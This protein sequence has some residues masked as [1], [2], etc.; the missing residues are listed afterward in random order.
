M[1]WPCTVCR[2]DARSRKQTVP[3]DLLGIIDGRGDAAERNSTPLPVDVP[4]VLGLQVIDLFTSMH[5]VGVA[6][7]VIPPNDILTLERNVASCDK[8][9]T[10]GSYHLVV[11]DAE[12]LGESEF[13]LVVDVV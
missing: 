12:E 11:A 5:S 7:D 1:G 6:T 13:V 2:A 10:S 4:A 9:G 3:R 8:G